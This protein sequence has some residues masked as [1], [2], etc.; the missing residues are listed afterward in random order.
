[1][2]PVTTELPVGTAIGRASKTPV[3][4]VSGLRAG[5]AN[6]RELLHGIDFGLAPGESLGI[7]GESGSG[8]TLTA[9]A[10]VGLLPHGVTAT[11]G[12]IRVDGREVFGS[13]AA[14]R[15]ALL[16]D[17]FGVVFQNPTV[18]L[19]PRLT[20]QQ[21]LREALPRQIRRSRARS[22]VRSLELLDHVGI[23]RAAERLRAFPY[24]LSGGMNQRVVIAMAIARSPRVLIA[25]E[26]TTALDVSVQKQ[27]LDL[28][29]RL[30]Q[31]LNL[32]LIIVS[33]DIG[34]IADRTDDV[35]VLKDG[36][37]VERGAVAQVLGAPQHEYTR[38]LLDAI[39]RLD[40][41]VPD[42]GGSRPAV[43]L[44]GRGLTREFPVAG[45]LRQK[46]R[47]LD[48][49]DVSLRQGQALAV[50]GESGSGKTT[51]ARILVGLD[52][53]DAGQLTAFGRPVAG[54]T[55]ARRRQQLAEVQYIFQDPYAALDPRQTVSQIVTE[56]IELS[57]SAEQRARK[58]EMMLELL[59]DVR[60]PRS[61][62][63]R[64]PR[65]L[66]GGQRQRVVIAR[67]LA[68]RPKVLIADEPVSSLDLS[69]QA[70]I[71]DLLATLRAERDLSYLVISHDL[72]VIRQLCTDVVVMRDGKV[73]ERG[74]TEEIFTSPR[75]AYTRQL[76]DA[77]PGGDWF[78]ASPGSTSSRET[79]PSI[80][81][82]YQSPEGD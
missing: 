31:E 5:L 23:G 42:D 74:T 37:V 52:R 30:R 7:V 44:E 48:A 58:R 75:D 10:V 64:K 61:F 51:L 72:A 81:T 28:I 35:L 79:Q 47:A 78:R 25:D 27:V 60:L 34:V 62:A 13:D 70:R 8:K 40:G 32:G 55:S 6:G 39:P 21:Q 12:S 45:N 11:S 50:V 41:E 15:R 56:P 82:R 43:V 67:A 1:V 57:G 73:V 2:T 46:V 17:C 71:L 76:L 65:Q 49:V 59:D 80:A 22:Y 53:A 3:L 38:A 4:E 69:V 19:N 66:S 14:T 36:S 63:D 20:I 54:R 68:L 9:M 16:R 29:D 24:E 26:A 77:I 18:S 33:H